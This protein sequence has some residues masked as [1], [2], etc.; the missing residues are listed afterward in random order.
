MGIGQNIQV[1]VTPGRSYYV[2]IDPRSTYL[3]S[4]IGL[5]GA[6]ELVRPNTTLLSTSVDPWTSSAYATAGTFVAY[7]SNVVVKLPRPRRHDRAKAVVCP[8]EPHGIAR[9]VPLG[10]ISLS[11]ERTKSKLFTRTFVYPPLPIAVWGLV[12]SFFVVRTHKPFNTA[13]ATLFYT[14]AIWWL[15]NTIS[16][17]ELGDTS[18]DIVIAYALSAVNFFLFSLVV[19]TPVT[20][21]LAACL[22]IGSISFVTSPFYATPIVLLLAPIFFSLDIPENDKPEKTR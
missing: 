4:G 16:A 22:C 7:D 15:A 14:D 2:L 10:L 17:S 3:S 1:D 5:V 19:S 12:K 21:S 8:V 13:V 9:S 11:A 20:Q 6:H 18:E